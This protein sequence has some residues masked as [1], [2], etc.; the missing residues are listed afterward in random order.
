[1][2]YIMDYNNLEYILPICLSAPTHKKRHTVN[3]NFDAYGL[4][5]LGN[6]CILRNNCQNK[7]PLSKLSRL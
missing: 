7:I 1:M 6:Y 5:G 3:S 2:S 4:K